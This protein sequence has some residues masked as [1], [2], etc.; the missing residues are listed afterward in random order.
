MK[1]AYKSELR[2][3]AALMA[4]ATLVFGTVAAFRGRQTAAL[5]FFGIGAIFLILGAAAPSALGGVHRGWMTL[6]RGLAWVNTRILL[7]LVFYGVLTPL[8]VIT[9]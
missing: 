4:G 9:R 5:I 6:A 2:K 1:V 3:F 8:R 7:G